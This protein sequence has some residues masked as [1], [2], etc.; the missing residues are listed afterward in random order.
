MS[1]EK[2]H[3]RIRLCAKS[4]SPATCPLSPPFPSSSNKLPPFEP[5]RQRTKEQQTTHK[6]GKKGKEKGGKK[7]AKKRSRKKIGSFSLIERVIL[8][9]G[10]MLIFCWKK[11]VH[12]LIE[13]GKFETL[14]FTSVSFQIDQMPEGESDASKANNIQLQQ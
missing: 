13:I 12:N 10:A 11:L 14:N 4:F 6:E 2:S 8:S 7:K 9:A 3:F 1:A 5:E